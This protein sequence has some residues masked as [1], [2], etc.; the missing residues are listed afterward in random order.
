MNKFLLDGENWKL[1]YVKNDRFQ[2]DGVS[3]DVKTLKD[4]GYTDIDA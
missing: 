2:K 3:V 4:R 1:I